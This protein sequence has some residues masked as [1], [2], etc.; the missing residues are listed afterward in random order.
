MIK[1]DIVKMQIV[2]ASIAESKVKLQRLCETLRQV[3]AQMFANEEQRAIRHE[4]EKQMEALEE[5]VRELK[6]MDE[7]LLQIISLYVKCEEA[8]AVYAE[9]VQAV[10]GEME[11][12][13]KE[14]PEWIFQLLR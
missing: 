14:V 6:R 9:E 10:S 13:V 5:N 3:S 2:E 8:V 7:G 12:G 11:F 1:T 4:L